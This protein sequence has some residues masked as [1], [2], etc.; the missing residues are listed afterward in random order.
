MNLLNHTI[1]LRKRILLQL[2]AI[3]KRR[4]YLVLSMNSVLL[5][6]CDLMDIS[7]L[8]QILSDIQKLMMYQYDLE[9]DRLHERYLPTSLE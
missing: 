2:L 1:L 8:W 3:R 5:I 7:V 4:L 9:D 6:S